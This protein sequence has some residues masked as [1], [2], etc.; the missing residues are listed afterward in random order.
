MTQFARDPEDRRA[1]PLVNAM[2]LVDPERGK[3]ESSVILQDISAE[4]GGSRCDV[5]QKGLQSLW[6]WLQE[7]KANLSFKAADAKHGMSSRRLRKPLAIPVQGATMRTF[8]VH[9]TQVMAGF[10]LIVWPPCDRKQRV[11]LG[12]ITCWPIYN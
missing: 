1:I 5:G 2:I 3:H 4:L 11:V 7:G 12:V 10:R 6:G 8:N 9:S